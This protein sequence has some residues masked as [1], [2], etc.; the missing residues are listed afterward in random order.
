MNIYTQVMENTTR[1]LKN[2]DEQMKKMATEPYATRRATAKEH[3]DFIRNL[4]PDQLM[5]LIQ[6]HG[7]Q[8]VDEY[9]RRYGGIDGRL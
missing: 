2:A 5:S 7:E 3:R 4:T 9:I 6:E 1:M 8:S